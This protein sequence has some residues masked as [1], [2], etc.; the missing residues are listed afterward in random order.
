MVS[1]EVAINNAVGDMG[2]QDQRMRPTFMRWAEQAERTIGS[3]YSL[4]RKYFTLPVSSDCHRVDLPC[5]VE[6]IMGIMLGG[7]SDCNCEA[8]FRNAYNYGAG[9]SYFYVGGDGVYRGSDMRQWEIQDGQI[10]FLYPLT[11]ISEITIDAAY[12]PMD[13][14]GRFLMVLD[15]HVDAIAAY[16]EMKRGKRMRW[17]PNKMSIYDMEDLRK[18]WGRARR[19]ARGNA[20]DPSPSEYAEVAAMINNPL[21]GW[22]GCMLRY[23]DEFRSTWGSLC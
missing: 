7:I 5:G 19:E 12:R 14:T 17:G 8:V 15:D 23:P 18:E 22:G 2:M 21:S 3:F 9:A 16:I 13:S 11:G 6:A 1:I 10:V 20:S 4:K